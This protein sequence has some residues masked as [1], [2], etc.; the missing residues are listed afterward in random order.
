MEFECLYTNRLILRK[1]SASTFDQLYKELSEEEQMH[2]LG[3]TTKEEL[4]AEQ[5]KYKEGLTTYN[6]KLLYFQLL[7]KTTERIIGWCGYHTWYIQ[8]RRAEIGY[9]LFEESLK[10]QG[11]MTEAME[12]IVEYGF[13]EMDLHRIEAFIGSDNVPSLKLIKKMNFIQEGHLKEH[14]FHE[15]K[16]EDSLVFALIKTDTVD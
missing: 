11:L 3:V 13:K 1:F 2:Y 6:R 12:V 9:G 14:Y 5:K 15:G 8:H 7:D 4:E 16:L 10:H